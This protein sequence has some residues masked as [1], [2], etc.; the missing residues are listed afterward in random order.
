VHGTDLLRQAQA[1]F[2]DVTEHIGLQKLSFIDT[3]GKIMCVDAIVHEH[4]PLY[5]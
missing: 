3:F 4:C 5:L 1:S 2:P